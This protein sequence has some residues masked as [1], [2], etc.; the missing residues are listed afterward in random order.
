M[1]FY[2]FLIFIIGHIIYKF[3]YPQLSKRGKSEKALHSKNK[4]TH[5]KKKERSKVNVSD[6]SS[7]KYEIARLVAPAL[8]G[9]PLKIFCHVLEVPVIGT[10]LVN[11]FRNQSGIERLWKYDLD[12]F[13]ATL[14]PIAIPRKK[15]RDH[16]KQEAQFVRAKG[17]QNDTIEDF[18]ES[19]KSKKTDPVEVV[20]KLIESSKELQRKFSLNAVSQINE[21]DALNQASMCKR[22]WEEGKERAF[23]G[24]P[25][26][27]KD[28]LKVKGYKNTVGTRFLAGE[29]SER[30][31]C[32]VVQR[33]KNAGFMVV[34]TTNMFEIGIMVPLIFFF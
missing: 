34:G 12:D 7:A 11:H 28:E 22:M 25:I 29:E 5:A 16:K 17:H 24:V 26:M 30:E 9:L 18:L 6:L 33:L 14:Q 10:L 19:Y 20:K 1:L 15:K 3:L 4:F 23:E 31:D 21:E 8:Y 2:L 13:P 32:L 27:V